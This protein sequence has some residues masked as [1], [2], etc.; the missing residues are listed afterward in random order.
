[1]TSDSRE[2]SDPISGATLLKR[3]IGRCVRKGEKRLH[4]AIT[5]NSSFGNVPRMRVR[6][7]VSFGCGLFVTCG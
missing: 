5:R 4:P 6:V 1:M 7:V 2:K 3:R